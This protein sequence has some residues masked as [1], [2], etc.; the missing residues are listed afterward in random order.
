LVTPAPITAHVAPDGS[1]DYAS[2]EKAVL[3]VPAGSTIILEA[4]SYRLA[5]PL[6]IEKTLYLIGAGMEQT[7]IVSDG[8]GFVVYFGINKPATVGGIVSRVDQSYTVEGITFRHKGNA[9]ADTVVVDG[10]EIAFTDL[11]FTGAVSDN[12]GDPS[13]G[14][15]VQGGATG[16]VW[17]CVILQNA[18]TG[19]IVEGEAQPTLEA[20]KVSGNTQDGIAYLGVSS[21]VARMNDCRDNGSS[22]ISVNDQAKPRLERNVCTGNRFGV[23]VQATADPVL[24]ENEVGSNSQAGIND[25]RL[26]EIAVATATSPPP[27]A[28][29]VSFRQG[30]ARYFDDPPFMIAYANT[31]HA[32]PPTAV[33]IADSGGM[34]WRYYEWVA[35]TQEGD[36][37]Q[38]THSGTA[39]DSVG[40]QFWGDASDGWA[41]VVV[42]GEERWRGSVYGTDGEWPGGAFVKYLQITELGAG[43]HTI[44]V[45]ALG[46]AGA[47]GGD[48]VTVLFFGFE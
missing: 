19:I 29:P 34:F 38:A 36:W 18:G 24:V 28:L 35:L 44:R 25:M 7:E 45:E 42:D 12:T 13:A 17:S 16:I 33:T 27:T 30:D 46:R 21:G 4:G 32:S 20:N 9:V 8:P 6:I 40:V 3:A 43:P 37:I 2:L 5:S 39:I 1:G 22:G 31:D 10:G 23:Y 47:G 26:R 14:L 11:S 15:R 41:R 48:D